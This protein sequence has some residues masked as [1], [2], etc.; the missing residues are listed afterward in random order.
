MLSVLVSNPLAGFGPR[1]TSVSC[2][3]R[4]LF[5]PFPFACYLRLKPLVT[6]VTNPSSS[7]THAFAFHS[8]LRTPLSDFG[9]SPGSHQHCVDSLSVLQWAAKK[10]KE[11]Y[12]ECAQYY[13]TALHA[14]S[15]AYTCPMHK[16]GATSRDGPDLSREARTPDV[17]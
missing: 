4:L 10:T 6:P 8:G 9:S 7:P 3:P 2:N 14:Y 5:P 16:L 11:L 17:G 13:H 1:E 12:V 15:L